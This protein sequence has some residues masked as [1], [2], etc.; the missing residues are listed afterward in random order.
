M[1]NETLDDA[2]FSRLSFAAQ[3]PGGMSRRRFMQ[4]AGGSAAVAVGGGILASGLDPLQAFAAP[5]I[6]PKDGVL[7]IVA[8][9]GGNDGLNTLIPYE[10]PRYY[11]LRDQVSIPAAQ[12]LP[13]GSGLGF[14]PS[15][16]KLKARFDLGQVAAVRGVGYQT[17]DL[18]HFTS[19]GIVMNG[20]AGGSQPGGPTGWIGRYLDGLPNAASESLLA[21][22]TGTSVPL[23][24]SGSVARASGI[25][26]SIES[27]FGVSRTDPSEARMFD[28]IAAFANTPTNLGTWGDTVADVEHD[29]LDLAQRIQPAYQGT[30]PATSLSRQLV[31]AARLI[32]TNLGLR[33]ISTSAGGFDTH[34]NQAATH[35]SL[36]S[37][38]DNSIEGFFATLS[39]ELRSQVTIMTFSE[40]GRRPIDNA[41][42]GT[43]HGTAGVQFLIGDRVKGGLHG[44]QPSLTTLDRY[45]NL[46]PT[47]DFRKVYATVFDKWLAADSQQLLSFNFGNLD[48]FQIGGPGEGPPQTNL[49]S[50]GRPEVAQGTASQSLTTGHVSET[51]SPVQVSSKRRVRIRRTATTGP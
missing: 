46:I 26:L 44:T 21:A 12:V 5:P 27:A 48:L 19:M 9:E 38:L 8:L 45:G 7:V 1:R 14:H 13:V 18:S 39:P 25:P 3:L 49:H 4:V 33:V 40:F 20:W 16:P 11:Q 50:D 23:H 35:A 24:M 22:V 42:G 43:D 30:F 28:A 32:N 36:L 41:T 15:L 29:A 31:L 47:V 17:P 2:A 10:D 51:L 6:G 34:S 37:D